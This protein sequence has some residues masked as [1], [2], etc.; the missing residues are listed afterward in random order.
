MTIK[1]ENFM[2]DLSFLQM[3]PRTVSRTEGATLMAAGGASIGMQ[4]VPNLVSKSAQQ[5]I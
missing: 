2:T 4:N 1:G 3:E 5:S